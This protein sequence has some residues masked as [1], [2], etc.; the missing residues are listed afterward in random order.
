MYNYDAEKAVH[1]TFSQLSPLKDPKGNRMSFNP[2]T[3]IF[4]KG[5]PE[6]FIAQ[7][8][9]G[10]I[11]KGNKPQS[12]ER[13]GS[14]VPAFEIIELPW[15]TTNT[16]HWWA[17]DSSI[18]NSYEGQYGLK[19]LEGQPI[20]LEGPYIVFNNKEMQWSSYYDCAIGHTDARGIA[21]SK[22]TNLS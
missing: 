16:S 5:S 10:A 4:S 8:V 9:L 6:S 1:Y 21:G 11:R 20:N 22:N 13:D 17:L 12:A 14:G 7:E 18:I 19:Y 3:R 15:I 2:D